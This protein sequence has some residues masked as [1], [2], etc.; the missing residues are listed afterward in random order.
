MDR[1]ITDNYDIELYDLTLMDKHFG[2]EIYLAETNK[3]KYIIKTMPYNIEGM[4]NE[5]HVTDFLLNNNIKTA[6]LLKTKDSSYVVKKDGR[7]VHVQEFIKGET[8]RVNT[9]P[10]WFLEK[11]A[12]ILGRINSVLKNYSAVCILSSTD[13]VPLYASIRWYS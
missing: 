9:A 6:K 3:G 5:G 4:E 2:T 13:N 11:S 1:L 10:E 12:D 8:L 7:G